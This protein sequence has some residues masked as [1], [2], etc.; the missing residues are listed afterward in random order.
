MRLVD[1]PGWPEVEAFDGDRRV[2][3]DLEAILA[4]DTQEDPDTPLR[5]TWCALRHAIAANPNPRRRDRA[6][7]SGLLRNE[8]E[9]HALGL[10]DRL[11]I[12]ELID[13]R[14]VSALSDP[15]PDARVPLPPIRLACRWG[16]QPDPRISPR[17]HRRLFSRLTLPLR[18]RM[19]AGFPPV[20][21]R[22]FG[23]IPSTERSMGDESIRIGS[24]WI[25]T[26]SGRRR[27]REE[28]VT[29]VLGHIDQ[30]RRVDVRLIS[31]DRTIRLRFGSIADRR[32]RRF[33]TRWRGV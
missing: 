19:G 6:F 12:T 13:D 9:L 33:W 7:Q 8:I 22:M 31:I 14:Y 1:A 21:D 27:I 18:R 26:A 29:V 23:A 17:W 4:L 30:D 15:V 11:G 32:F 20:L 5:E 10:R 25:E 28:F 2:R 3:V 16:G 24:G